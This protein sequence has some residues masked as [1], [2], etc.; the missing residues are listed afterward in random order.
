MITIKAAREKLDTVTNFQSE[1][2]RQK[3]ETERADGT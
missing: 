2:K 1:Q 3:T